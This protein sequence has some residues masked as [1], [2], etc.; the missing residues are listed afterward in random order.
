MKKIVITGGA[1][2]I[3]SI[4]AAKAISEGYE[5][6]V[7]D[8]FFFGN[9]GLDRLGA[10]LH[11]NDSRTFPSEILRG[12]YA[13]FDLAAIS[14]DP[15]GELNP[16]L[17]MDINYRARRRLQELCVQEKV[18]RYV[19]ASSCSVYGFQ[20]EVV[21][22]QSSVN[23][24]TTYAEANVLAENSAFNLA[25]SKTI[26]TA[27]RQ[28]T[29]FGQSPRMRFDLAV[30]AMTLNLWKYGK[31]KLLRNGEQWRPMIHVQDTSSA[32]LEV[33]KQPSH[34]VENQIF[35][36]GSDTQNYQIIRIAEE[37][38]ETLGRPMDIE[39]YGD[40]DLRSYRVSFEKI[41]NNLG[42][43][44]KLGVPEATKEIVT[45]LKNGIID[46][47][48]RTRTVD[49]Y[50]KLADWTSTLESINQTNKGLF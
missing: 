39:W 40:E 28:A 7:I 19:L 18:E 3:G 11:N 34:I 48:P 12:A 1:G 24:L 17:T 33:I 23:P 13:V 36:T 10:R 50:R 27:L 37:I 42:F 43:Q 21:N 46:D 29:V 4:L 5:V 25:G 30:N 35:N 26:F 44:T 41:T 15:A 49:W 8:R 22:E 14:N 45:A 38:A 6:H 31:L 20:N 32:F 16:T 2:Y 9:Q 47:G